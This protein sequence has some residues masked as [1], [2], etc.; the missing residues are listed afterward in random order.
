MSANNG[1]LQDHDASDQVF[2]QLRKRTFVEPDTTIVE[3]FGF[4]S[5]DSRDATFEDVRAAIQEEMDPESLPPVEWIFLLPPPVGP[6]RRTQEGRLGPLASYLQ[7]T[8]QNRLGDGT[9]DN[10][11]RLVLAPITEWPGFAEPELAQMNEAKDAVDN[12]PKDDADDD[13][14]R[15]LQSQVASRKSGKRAG[16]TSC[17]HQTAR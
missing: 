1:Y 14:V 2:F 15:Q 8:F 9:V 17:S 3:L 4:V 12:E 7:R 11:L 5:L 10:P 6:V 13:R 16:R